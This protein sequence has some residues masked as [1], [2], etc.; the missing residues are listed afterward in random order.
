[1][2]AEREI[3]RPHFSHG[4]RLSLLKQM[5]D[6]LD[7]RCRL[8]NEQITSVHYH[9]PRPGCDFQIHQSC[10]ESP[11]DIQHPLHAH[12]LSLHLTSHIKAQAQFSGIIKCNACGQECAFAS[13]QCSQCNFDL[14]FKCAKLLPVN[15]Q[16]LEDSKGITYPHPLFLLQVNPNYNF[17]SYKCTCCEEELLGGLIYVCLKSNALLHKSCRELPPQ[18]NHP[19]HPL[20][21]L[22]LLMLDMHHN[23]NVY[24]GDLPPKCSSCG[25]FLGRFRY[26]C[27]CGFFLDIKCAKIST[28]AHE[29][30]QTVKLSHPHPL[31]QIENYKL[32]HSILCKGCDKHFAIRESAYFCH[33]CRMWMHKSCA[34][35]PREVSH[36]LDPSHG[37]TLLE[38]YNTNKLAGKGKCYACQDWI[39]GFLYQCS[40]CGLEIDLRCKSSITATMMSVDH[41]EHPLL[42]LN[43]SN[44]LTSTK[45]NSCYQACRPPFFRCWKC[46]LNL[47]VH[48]LRKL[49]TTVKSLYH[50]HPLTLNR[51]PIKDYSD[52]G[53]DAEFYCDDCEGLRNLYDPSYYCEE[54]HYVA[55]IHCF[56]TEVMRFQK[57]EWSNADNQ[58]ED[59]CPSGNKL[60]DFLDA[61]TESMR[62]K[63]VLGKLSPVE[64]TKRIS[65]LCSKKEFL[66]AKLEEVDGEIEELE[67]DLQ[68]RKIRMWSRRS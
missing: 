10:A 9:C 61:L 6:D 44:D 39:S 46:K 20:H 19:F 43:E 54:C 56:L 42:L 40:D 41:R 27:E 34:D 17:I 60:E 37:L 21:P 22:S 65:L 67:M 49:P 11:K 58:L 66:I 1:M 33:E 38:N 57:E 13:Y 51:S 12:P 29:E 25:A 32:H 5:P 2:E 4:H 52:E 47:H 48:C 18:L 50:R 45:C 30:Y 55:H 8:C 14:D 53:D 28:K 64:T 62:R 23:P 59:E 26:Q 16:I 15:T 3:V 7:K 31:L 24:G 36:P 68:C 35:L 63:A